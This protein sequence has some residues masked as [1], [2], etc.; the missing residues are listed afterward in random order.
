VAVQI[1]NVREILI[2]KIAYV[3][4]RDQRELEAEIEANGGDLEIDSKVGQTVVGHLE[5]ALDQEG[6]VRVSDQTKE[7]LTTLN[8]LEAMIERR[9]EETK[10]DSDG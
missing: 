5:M 4:N 8:A 3:R 6:L 9:R 2:E 7:N 10:G 1:A